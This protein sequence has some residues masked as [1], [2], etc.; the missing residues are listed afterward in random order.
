MHRYE[1]KDHP[2]QKKNPAIHVISQP[3][4]DALSTAYLC[5]LH[6]EH[7]TKME[8]RGKEKSG[9]GDSSGLVLKKQCSSLAV[10]RWDCH[11][12]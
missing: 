8:L 10:D 2:N 6:M 7:D 5:T 3:L 12:C 1:R 9:T 11:P 4:H